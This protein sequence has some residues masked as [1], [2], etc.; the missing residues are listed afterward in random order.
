[1]PFLLDDVVTD[2]DMAD[3]FT[4]TR[5]VG[6]FVAG[7]WAVTST[8][9]I[10]AFGV[11]AVAEPRTLEMVQEGDRIKGAIQIHTNQ[12]LYPTLAWREGTSD[13]VTWLGDTW[14]VMESSPWWNFGY[15]MSILVRM[16]G[17]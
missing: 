12:P 2:F 14:R 16:E 8:W 17:D 3:S 13:T 15:W 9:T 11:V 1:M 6:N 7:G 10:N 4:I 5:N